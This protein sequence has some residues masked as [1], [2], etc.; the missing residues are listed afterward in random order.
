MV[1]I[2]DSVNDKIIK[3][4]N[5]TQYDIMKYAVISGFAVILTDFFIDLLVFHRNRGMVYVLNINLSKVSLWN[6]FLIVLSFTLFGYIMVVYR[7]KITGEREDVDGYILK[8]I[9]ATDALRYNLYS[10]RLAI[11]SSNNDFD[12]TKKVMDS[13]EEGLKVSIDLIDSYLENAN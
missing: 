2:L 10:M 5:G 9:E 4:L 6:S 11:H 12:S 7:S 13:V 8:T 1:K 3:I